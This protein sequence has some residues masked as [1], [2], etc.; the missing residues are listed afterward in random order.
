[1]TNKISS[2]TMKSTNNIKSIL[3]F[4][5]RIIG[6]GINKTSGGIFVVMTYAVCGFYYTFLDLSPF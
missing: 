1:M 4:F 6:Y 5:Y 3:Q 2:I